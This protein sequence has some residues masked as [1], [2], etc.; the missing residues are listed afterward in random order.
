[1]RRP[2]DSRGIAVQEGLREVPN[3]RGNREMPER[4]RDRKCLSELRSPHGALGLLGDDPIRIHM[5]PVDI[6]TQKN[7]ARLLKRANVELRRGAYMNAR[8][9][10]DRNCRS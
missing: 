4:M 10:A 5:K 6:L 7:Q 2:K 8:N 1:M 3:L 9:I